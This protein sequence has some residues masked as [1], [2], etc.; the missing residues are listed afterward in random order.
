MIPVTYEVQVWKRLYFDTQKYSAIFL[1][2]WIVYKSI[3]TTTTTFYLTDLFVGHL[4]AILF[5]NLIFLPFQEMYIP[6]FIEEM[7]ASHI[8]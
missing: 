7:L 2:T 4:I 5:Y 8:T 6:E 1:M 3:T